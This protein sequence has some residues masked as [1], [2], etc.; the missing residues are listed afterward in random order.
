MGREGESGDGSG[1]VRET[2]RN[3]GRWEGVGV[4]GVILRDGRAVTGEEDGLWGALM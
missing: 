2:G 3:I 4:G 1:E